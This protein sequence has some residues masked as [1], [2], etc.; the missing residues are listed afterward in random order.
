MI[1]MEDKFANPSLYDLYIEIQGGRIDRLEQKPIDLTA[2]GSDDLQQKLRIIS[3]TD[4]FSRLAPRNQRLLAFSAQWF[5]VEAG[6]FIFRQGDPPDAA[7]LCISGRAA[8]SFRGETGERLTISD[9][10]PGRVVGDL[11]VIMDTNRQLDMIALEK[12]TFLRIG[13]AEFLSVAKSDP[14]V[15]FD[16]LRTV[17]G[18]LTGAAEL[19]RSAG[20]EPPRELP[21]EPNGVPA[22]EP[23]RAGE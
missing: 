10:L 14:Q 16:L 13:G 12:S 2:E 1:F 11:A 4:L 19:I 5:E 7:Y 21:I 9:V 8:M 22:D 23:R 17:A 3:Q 6:Q 15:T 20:I 18:H